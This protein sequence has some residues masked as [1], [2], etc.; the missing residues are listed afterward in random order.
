MSIS[1]IVV[2]ASHEVRSPLALRDPD[3]RCLAIVP[4][5]V[6]EGRPGAFFEPLALAYA[7]AAVAA[8]VV[9]L[10][11]TPA[12]S[13]MLFSRGKPGGRESPL[14]RRLTPRYDGALSRFVRSA[15]Q[16]R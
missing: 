15:A 4:V 9:A 10:T 3:R 6:M 14:V 16:R 5:A 13:L 2:E 11:L 7:L 1:Q 12:L 8:M